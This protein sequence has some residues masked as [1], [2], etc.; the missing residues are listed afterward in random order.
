[1]TT[2]AW[3]GKTLAADSQS[4]VVSRVA[5]LDAKKIMTPK[6]GEEVW[7]IH[8]AQILAVALAGDSGGMLALK[9]ALRAGITVFTELPPVYRFQALA[10]TEEGDAYLLTLDEEES[11]LH[12]TEVSTREAMGSGEDFAIAAMHMGR[13][14]IEAVAVASDLDVFTGGPIHSWTHPK[15]RDSG[16]VVY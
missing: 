12:V 2:I 13:D 3:D 7:T 6:P 15:D 1:M 4:T 5:T 8:G 9:S 14:A 11:C 10:V 16:L